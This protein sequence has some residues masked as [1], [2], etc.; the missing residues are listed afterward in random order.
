MRCLLFQVVFGF[1]QYTSITDVDKKISSLT[2]EGGSCNAGAALNECQ[3]SIFDGDAGGRRRILLVIMTG[4]SDDDIS[5]TAGSLTKTG[6][7]II[8][9][10]MGLSYDRI[11]LSAMAFTQSYVFTT[12]SIDGWDGI[13]GS[14]SQLISLGKSMIIRLISSTWPFLIPH[15][16]FTWCTWSNPVNKAGIIK[17]SSVIIDVNSF[18]FLLFW[19]I[20]SWWDR[21]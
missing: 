19:Q 21:C 13:I 2:F 1:N 18:I 4:T 10:G 3:T 15:F 5:T 17:C 6:V 20:F 12:A 7:K 8:A 16:L 11:Q 9:V 14:V